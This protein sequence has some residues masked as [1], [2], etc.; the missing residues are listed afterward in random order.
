MA[1]LFAWLSSPPPAPTDRVLAVGDSMLSGYR[2]PPHQQWYNQM[3]AMFDLAIKAH[4]GHEATQLR[5]QVPP[6]GQYDWQV[7]SVGTNDAYRGRPLG[8]YGRSLREAIRG[9]YAPQVVV[10]G[11]PTDLR[12]GAEGR[13]RAFREVAREAARKEGAMYLDLSRVI[14]P[15]RRFYHPDRVH[16]NADG[17][18]HMASALSRLLIRAKVESGG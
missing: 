15:D 4:R 14:P 3:P 2:Q 1:G 7:I 13:L 17:T 5:S 11:P 18:A 8:T 16:L 9:R 6:P 12:P 10:L